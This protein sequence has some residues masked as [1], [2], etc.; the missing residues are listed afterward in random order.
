MAATKICTVFQGEEQSIETASTTT[1]WT[2][3]TVSVTETEKFKRT[4][5]R[6]TWK[7]TYKL[8]SS[9]DAAPSTQVHTGPPGWETCSN[10]PNAAYPLIVEH[11]DVFATYGA[12]TEDTTP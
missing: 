8:D 4:V 6:K 11:L 5:T 12:W 10:T 9:S 7:S 3:D 1:S 2:A